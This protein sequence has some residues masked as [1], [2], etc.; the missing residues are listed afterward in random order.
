[1]ELHNYHL[2]SALV[3]A[4]NNSAVGRLKFTHARLSKKSRQ[5]LQDLESVVSMEGAF[6]NFRNALATGGPPA[7]P[8]MYVYNIITK[9]IYL[10]IYLFIFNVGVL[11]SQ[12]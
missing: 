9:Y 8:F 5:Q 11:I 4:I 12:I 6:K 1:M 3:S 7:I 2:V 10:F